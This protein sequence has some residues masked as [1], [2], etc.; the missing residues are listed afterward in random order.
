[1]IG[2]LIAVSVLLLAVTA[3]GIVGLASLV[4]QRTK[5]IGIRR[6]LG[7]TRGQILRYFQT[8]N[9]LLATLGIVLGMLLAFGINQWL[10]G[11]YELPRLPWYYLPV[12]AAALWGLGQSPCSA[13]PARRCG[14]ARRG[15]AH[16]L[17]FPSSEAFDESVMPPFCS[18][19]PLR[20]SRPSRSAA[21]GRPGP[22]GHH[23]RARCGAVR[24]L[25]PLRRSGAAG[26]CRV[27]DPAVEFTTTP[28]V[29]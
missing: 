4:Q 6:A 27:L 19:C 25:Q 24:C 20:P 11:S 17:M 15:H 21:A 3:L 18:P 14:A 16:G 28:A 10:M 5:Q 26:A 1:M 2:L 22:S 23:R 9:F 12:G 7:A 8:E 29:T 13:G